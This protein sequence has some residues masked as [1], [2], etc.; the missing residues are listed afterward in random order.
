VADVIEGLRGRLIVSCQAPAGSPL[1]DPRHLAALA[2][3]AERGGAG[4]IRAEG[5]EAIAAIRAVVSVP[6][7]G[8]RK[9]RVEGSPV[10]ITP[11]VHDA[12]EVAEAGADI[13]AFD[14]TR[15][16]RPGGDGPEAFIGRLRAALGTDVPLLADVDDV[17]AGQVAAAAGADA[18]ASTLAGYTDGGS[19]PVA[20]DPDLE[21]LAGLVDRLDRPVLAEG[22]YSTPQQVADAFAAGA[23]AVVVGTAI[24]DALALTR[25]FAAAAPGA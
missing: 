11:E 6:I 8:L 5:A 16:P 1:R 7:I 22:R 10:Y 24:T 19:G 12:I 13:V 2:A 15:R 9:R 17:G 25:R 18:V 20:T 3:A 4:A 14:A 21:I 23:H